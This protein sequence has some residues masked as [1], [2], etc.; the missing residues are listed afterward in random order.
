MICF[1]PVF[2]L[3]KIS[4]A[5]KAGKAGTVRKSG[6]CLHCVWCCM[7]P[8]IFFA[9]FLG[10]FIQFVSG[11]MMD[12]CEV[13]DLSLSKQAFLE[14]LRAQATTDGKLLHTCIFGDG[15]M[16]NAMGLQD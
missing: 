4:S 9:L 7:G 2:C 15:K 11:F 16:L 8:V 1:L 10:I 3:F 6:K 13:L 5:Y 12:L 14:A